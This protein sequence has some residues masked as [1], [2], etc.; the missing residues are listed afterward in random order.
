MTANEVWERYVGSESPREW[1]DSIDDV[2]DH[3]IAI[4]VADYLRCEPG[5]SFCAETFEDPY[6]IAIPLRDMLT[7]YRDSNSSEAN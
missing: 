2:S 4:S 6:R 1:L 3:G 7:E 5:K